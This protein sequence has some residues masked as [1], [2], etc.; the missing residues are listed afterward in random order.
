MNCFQ[1]FHI[2]IHR[3]MIPI[4]IAGQMKALMPLGLHERMNYSYFTEVKDTEIKEI[5]KS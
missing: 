2:M 4:H 1:L 5:D 3:E